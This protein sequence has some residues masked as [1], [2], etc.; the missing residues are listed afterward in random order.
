DG[1][2]VPDE[3]GAGLSRGLEDH[4][5]FQNPLAERS[6]AYR[7]FA[8]HAARHVVRYRAMS[9]PWRLDHTAKLLARGKEL[10]EKLG[11]TYRLVVA[12]TSVQ[13]EGSWKERVLGTRAINE[14]ILSRAA[15]DG[16][17]TLDLLD[18]LRAGR[19]AGKRLYFPVDQHWD[20]SGHDVVGDALTRELLE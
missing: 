20:P 2:L 13:V 9:E 1:D 3:T 6:R 11:A 10:S 19:A 14:G 8:W 18:A 4:F 16:L 12:P 17:E 15:R 5:I 7:L